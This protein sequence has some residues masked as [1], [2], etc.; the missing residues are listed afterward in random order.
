M[1]DKT[2]LIFEKNKVIKFCRNK[3]EFDKEMFIYNMNLPFVP[4]L[5]GFNS[6]LSIIIE[7][8][9]GKTLLNL[10]PDFQKLAELILLLYVFRIYYKSP[11]STLRVIFIL[12]PTF[13]FLPGI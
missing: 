8:V 4:K 10:D 1:T 13:I 9:E 7:R 2:K 12:V 5:I 11:L 6:D 3:A